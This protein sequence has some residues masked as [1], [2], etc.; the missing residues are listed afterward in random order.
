MMIGCLLQPSRKVFHEPDQNSL[1]I[2]WISRF[3]EYRVG[4]AFWFLQVRLLQVG[5]LQVGLLQAGLLQV[6]RQTA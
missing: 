5:L 3:K 6:R 4:T 2:N 1:R